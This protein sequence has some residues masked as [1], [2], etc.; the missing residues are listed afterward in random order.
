MAWF[1]INGIGKGTPT[2][3]SW[4][5]KMRQPGQYY[6]WDQLLASKLDLFTIDVYWSGNFG[7]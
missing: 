2:N 4:P 5:S 3:K 6:E 7:G 1:S